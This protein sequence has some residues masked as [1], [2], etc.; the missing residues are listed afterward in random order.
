[1]PSF[2][3]KPGDESAAD[4][5]EVIQRVSRYDLA[6]VLYGA[7]HTRQEVLEAASAAIPVLEILRADASSGRDRI[8]PAPLP[9]LER[10]VV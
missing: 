10:T 5:A 6:G 8:V 9:Q 7:F 1:V 4:D 2:W 3:K